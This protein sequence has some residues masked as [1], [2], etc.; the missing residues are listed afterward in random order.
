MKLVYPKFK[1]AFME[2]NNIW[3]VPFGVN[4]VFRV[5]IKKQCTFFVTMITIESYKNNSFGGIMKEG[6]KLFLI[7]A[8]WDEFLIYDLLEKSFTRIRCECEGTFKFG[9]Y[10][11]DEKNIYFIGQEHALI[12][13]YHIKKGEMQFIDEFKKEKVCKTDSNNVLWSRGTACLSNG[14]LL[15]PNIHN[16]YVLDYDV[17]NDKYCLHSFIDVKDGFSDIL[18]V[19]SAYWLTPRE[20]NKILCWKREE[21][22]MCVVDGGS[23]FK[24]TGYMHAFVWSRNNNIIIIDFSNLDAFLVDTKKMKISPLDINKNMN[25]QRKA[26]Q[27][28]VVRW[29]D[30]QGNNIYINAIN[31]DELLVYDL[32]SGK[33]NDL[34][35]ELEQQSRMLYIDALKKVRGCFAETLPYISLSALLDYSEWIVPLNRNE[36]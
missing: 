22:Q 34:N 24:A 2:D 6:D 5:D 9:G 36:D 33:V 21:N 20:G 19:E 15:I 32:I 7:P 31:N 25:L 13:K 10:V 4:A 26:E 27:S 28:M 1:Y 35:I 3:F 23:E 16:S 30:I 18:Y 11:C 17:K 29:V 8:S 14:S 12:A